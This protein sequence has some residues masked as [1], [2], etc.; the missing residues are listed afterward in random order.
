MSTS[1]FLL[2]LPYVAFVPALIGTHYVYDEWKQ[3]N[4]AVEE[5]R[6]SI[7]TLDDKINALRRE[8]IASRPKVTAFEA[9][10]LP[11]PMAV[12]PIEQI[13]PPMPV[14]A[15]FHRPR[16]IPQ[17]A[18]VIQAAAPKSDMPDDGK[19]TLLADS[20]KS[21]PEPSRIKLLGDK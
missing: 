15:T 18:Q 11:E 19:I 2:F 12:A 6:D 8:L 3:L 14:Q 17:P 1:K 7:S 9:P 4:A 10:P 5:S 21:T 13:P 16:S 20:K